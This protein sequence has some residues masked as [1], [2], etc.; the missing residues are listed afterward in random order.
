MLYVKHSII[1]KQLI[2]SAVVPIMP[3]YKPFGTKIYIDSK[4][5]ESLWQTYYNIY[6]E[7]ETQ[8]CVNITTI[9]T[10]NCGEK[11]CLQTL[12]MPNTSSDNLH[13]I[14]IQTAMLPGTKVSF[15]FF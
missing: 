11:I 12:R 9:L 4:S 2:N 3:S 1:Q 10:C 5:K 8:S 14:S 13:F 7:V 15:F 6:M